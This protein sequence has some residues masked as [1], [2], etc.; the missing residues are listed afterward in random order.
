M[1][2]F[3]VRSRPLILLALSIVGAGAGTGCGR[4]PG[5]FEIVNNQVPTADCQIPTNQ[6]IY[7]GEGRLDLSLVSPGATSPTSSFRW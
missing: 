5:Q 3:N 4:V 6:T 2:G 1:I 7:R